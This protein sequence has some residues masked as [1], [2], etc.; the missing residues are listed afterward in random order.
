MKNLATLG[1]AIAMSKSPKLSRICR[2][3]GI[4]QKALS[5]FFSHTQVSFRAARSYI[6]KPQILNFGKFWRA[7][8]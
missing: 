1:H 6:F 8:K 3:E 7:L 5:L 2:L 4:N